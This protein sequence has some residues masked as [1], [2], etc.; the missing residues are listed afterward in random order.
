MVFSVSP[1]VTVREIDL[2]SNIPAVAS[3]QGAIA[4]VFNWGPVGEVT[5]ITSESELVEVFGKPTNDNFETFFTAADFLSYSNQLYVVRAD[6]E[7][8]RATAS[9]P[10]SNTSAYSFEAKHVGE[11][12]NAIRISY[13]SGPT[14]YEQVMFD[15]SNMSAAI[16]NTNIFNTKSFAFDAGADYTANLRTGDIIK[17]GNPEVG[18]Q[19]LTLSTFSVTPIANTAT[20]RYDM[21][22]DNSYILAETDI[23]ELE[24]SRTW[25]YSYIFGKAPSAGNAHFVIVDR[26]GAITGTPGSIL[27]RYVDV[28]FTPG[29]TRDDGTN[30]YYKDILNDT[31]AWVN[32][33]AA[34]ANL[35]ANEI[36]Y[37]NMT[38]GTR[39]LTE[40]GITF[41]KISLAYDLFKNSEEF[42][43]AFILQG[44]TNNGVN[45]A[46]YIIGNIC[47]VRKDCILFVSPSRESILSGSAPRASRNEILSNILTFRNTL[48][49]SSYWFMDTGYKYRYDKYNDSYRWVP[50]NGDIAGLSAR[51]E[52]WESPAGYKRGII[53]NVVKLAYNPNKAQRDELYAR[54][55][56]AVISQAGQGT[57][58]FGDKTGLGRPSAFDRI[59]VRR[60]FIIVEKAIATVSASLLFDINDEFTQTEFRNTVEPFLRDIKGRR[61]ITDFRVV[62][63]ARVNTPDVI[64]RNIFRANIF[65][66]PARTINFIELT[67]VATRTGISFEEIVGQQF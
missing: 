60:L 59:N 21:T 5:L 38:G 45:L 19:N 42:D 6:N 50:L 34:S 55:V 2:T 14:D 67:F 24:M 56:N 26:T 49:S 1:S 31:S 63:D 52:P 20:Y 9:D 27:E 23:A 10:V 8:T 53:K 39:G 51:I 44:K 32:V 43:I 25:G 28:S 37:L 13:V 65:I 58:L 61:G 4:G 40:T 35:I 36:A 22:F 66:K 62:S 47:E 64:D 33:Q 17:V 54:D 15:A 16:A 48:Q 30:N 11:L 57:L 7:A 29:A 41:N 18:Y 46:N 12:G 3:N